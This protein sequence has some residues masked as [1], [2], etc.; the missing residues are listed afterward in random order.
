M[1]EWIAA[2]IAHLVAERD[3]SPNTVSA[4]RRDLSQFA[5]F[6]DAERIA[7]ANVAEAHVARFAQALADSGLSPAS[8]ARKL[9]AVRVFARFLVSEELLARDF[10][11]LM[12]PR[13]AHRKLPRTLSVS[14]TAKLVE[15]A[16]G[17]R[18]KDLRDRALVEL[19]YATGLRVSEAVG[20][21]LRDVDL[22]EGWVRC[23]G[24]GS[25]ERIVPIGKPA[26]GWLQD[27]LHARAAEGTASSYLFP[28]RG[29]RPLSRQEAWRVV[30]RCALRAGIGQRVTPH[31]LRHSFAT[32]L[33]AGGADIRS[34]QEMLGHARL[35]TTQIYAHVDMDRVKDAY[36]RSHP[37]A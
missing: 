5:A 18:V 19:L 32:H 11:E 36:R 30:K 17:Q 12:E 10:T 13:K 22:Q 23:V 25:K 29:D 34:I 16:S 20:L 26:C 7:P 28:G 6:L 33:L 27:Y 35:A 9:T 1:D 31:T 4:Y 3:L 21:R 24:K 8:I 2:F 14:R 15:A 37:R